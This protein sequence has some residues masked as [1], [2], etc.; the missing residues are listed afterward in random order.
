MTD[1]LIR[2]DAVGLGERIRQKEISPMELPEAAIDQIEGRIQDMTSQPAMSVPLY[3]NKADIPIGVQFAGR[4]GDE[5][6]LFHLA[7]QLEN[8]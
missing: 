2:Y 7:A 8:D 4:F 5:G 3:W 6:T 1:E